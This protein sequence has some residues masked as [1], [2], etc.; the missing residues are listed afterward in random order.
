MA[1]SVA[2]LV[3]F[4][5]PDDYFAGFVGRVHRV[6]APDVERVAAQYLDPDRFVTLLVGDPDVVVPLLR[7]HGA[8][9]VDV[10]AEP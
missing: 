8:P 1:R 9:A 10:V 7:T 5:L 2:T 3:A 6:T 4:D